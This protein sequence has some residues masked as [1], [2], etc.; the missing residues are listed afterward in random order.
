MSSTAPQLRTRLPRIA[1]AALQRARLTVVPRPR[2][3]AARAPRVPFVVLV[4]AILLAGV[5]GLL[6][7][8]TS[9]QAASFRETAL[10]QQAR[11]LDAR[12]ESLEIQV[13][14]LRDENRIARKAQEMGMVIPSTPAA[15][16]DLATGEIIGDPVPAAGGPL[17][18]YPPPP[19]RP[20]SLDPET[21]TVPA[22]PEAGSDHRHAG[23]RNGAPDRDRRSDGPR[24][25]NGRR[26]VGR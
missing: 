17:P 26:T 2:V 18:L 24:L 1:D 16:L 10:E 11:D 19:T 7:F 6:M 13:E 5:V 9:M 20:A 15:S 23:R 25:E 14:A 12:Q 3:R 22:D 8:N 21:V 4:S